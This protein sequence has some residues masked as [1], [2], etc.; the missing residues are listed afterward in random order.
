VRRRPASRGS[1]RG[2][3]P[4]D[5]REG[6]ARRGLAWCAAPSSRDGLDRRRPARRDPGRHFGTPD[7]PLLASLSSLLAL[8]VASFVSSPRTRRSKAVTTGAAPN[9][10]GPRHVVRLRPTRTDFDA[11][12]PIAVT[13]RDRRILEALAD[14]GFLSTEVVVRAFFPGARGDEP[15]PD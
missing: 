6:Q 4:S 15:G 11:R 2:E 7:S 9:V 14:F 10:L 8:F 12:K 3:S 13:E 5:G 1:R